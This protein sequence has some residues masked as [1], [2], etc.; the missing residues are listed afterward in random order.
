MLIIKPMANSDGRVALHTRFEVSLTIAAE[1]GGLAALIPW[2][3]ASQAIATLLGGVAVVVSFLLWLRRRAR[4]ISQD[5]NIAFISKASSGYSKVFAESLA[6]ELVRRLP[7]AKLSM[8]WAAVDEHGVSFRAKFNE[9]IEREAVPD[10][11]VVIVPPN[12]TG[13]SELAARA[14]RRKIAVLC[15]DQGFET[16]YFHESGLIPPAVIACDNEKGG[17][18][19]AQ[20][21]VANL[22]PGAKVG[23]VTGP[24]TSQ[25]SNA[26][27]VAFIRTALEHGLHICWEIET[28]WDASNKADAIKPE[29]R[30]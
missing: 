30:S 20:V 21:L 29:I 3:Q 6:G 18:L 7:H 27:K 8:D 11:I 9:V 22:K 13:L 15:I 23:L 19:A 2:F 25:P 16:D 4:R 28:D 10:V 26:R 1:L 17:T 14:L 24:A 12:R 5:P